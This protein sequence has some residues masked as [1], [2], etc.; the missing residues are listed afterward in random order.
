MCTE[1]AVFEMNASVFSKCQRCLWI[2]AF[3]GDFIGG[4]SSVHTHHG[5]LSCAMRNIE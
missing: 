1:D 4:A 5:H 2:E 3:A